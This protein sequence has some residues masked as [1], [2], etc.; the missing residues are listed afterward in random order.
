MTEFQQNDYSWQMNLTIN[1]LEKKKDFGG[2]VCAS[3]NALGKAEAVVRLQGNN[4]NFSS[5]Y[6]LKFIAQ[7][8]LHDSN[9]IFR[10]FE[11]FQL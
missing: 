4:N 3:V 5:N 9:F 10:F 6:Q 2:Y 11:L 7:S 1:N 8:R